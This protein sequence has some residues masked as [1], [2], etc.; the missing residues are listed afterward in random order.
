MPDPSGCPDPQQLQRLAEGR[1]PALDAAAL[2]QHVQGCRA[3]AALVAAQQEGTTLTRVVPGSAGAHPDEGTQVLASQ[4]LGAQPAPTAVLPPAEPVP[5]TLDRTAGPS[6]APGEGRGGSLEEVTSCLAPPQAPDEIGRLGSYR[7]LRVLGSGGMG[8][9]FESEDPQL[10]RRVALKVMRP[11]LAASATGRQRFIREAQLTASLEHDHI[12]EIHEVGEDRGVL[13]L[14]MQ[15][16]EGESLEDRLRRE[17]RLPLPEVLR[18]GRETTEGLVAAHERGLIHRDIKPANIWLEARGGPRGMPAPRPRVK[19]LDFGLARALDSDLHLT[20]S[21]I[22]AGT[23]QYMAPEQA[24]GGAVDARADLFSLGCVLYRMATGQAPFHGATTMAVL[25][26]LAVE[27][28]PDPRTLNPEVPPELAEL[29]GRQLAKRPVDRPATAQQVALTLQGLEAGLLAGETAEWSL[30]PGTAAAIAAWTRP[31]QPPVGATPGVSTVDLRS[32]RRQVGL[33]WALAAVLAALVLMTAGF[34]AVRVWWGADT[35]SRAPTAAD[36]LRREDMPPRVLAAAGDGD[37]HKAPAELVAVF[38]ETR[39]RSPA[40]RFK[41]P[42]VGQ[43]VPAHGIA[44]SSAGLLATASN[45]PFPQDEGGS[46]QLWD[47]HTGKVVRT[48]G[49]F[50]GGLLPLALSPDG[51]RLAAGLGTEGKVWDVNTGEPLFAL[52]WHTD[53][54]TC[55]AY[56]RDGKRLATGSYDRTVR[57]WDA[58]TAREEI[59]LKGH[60]GSVSAVVFHPDGK[61]LATAGADGH[62]RL[63]DLAGEREVRGFLLAAPALAVAVSPDGK[64]LAGGS[65]GRLKVW[66]LE[67]GREVLTL[68][69]QGALISGLA[70]SPDGKWLAGAG[71]QGKDVKVWNV[72]TWQE[73][74]TLTGNRGAVTALAFRA[75]G[76]RLAGGGNDQTVSLW[77]LTTDPERPPSQWHTGPVLA[78]AVSPDGNT[79]ASAGQDQTIRLWDIAGARWRATLTGHVGP[80]HHIAFSPDGQVL[81]SA[82]DDLTIKLWDVA[83]ARE[84]RTLRGHTERVTWVAFSADGGRLVS[85]GADRTV[86][87]WDSAT[88]A[89]LH[90]FRGHSA[91]VT[92]AAFSPDREKVVSGGLDKRLKVWELASG[93]AV[94]TL[95]GHTAAVS[96]LA[97][98]RGGS[99]LAS[100]GADQTVRLWDLDSGRER[101]TLIGHGAPVTAVAFRE[102]GHAVAS[103]S[104]D[105]TVRLWDL[106][107]DP[108]GKRIVRLFPPGTAV[109][110][111]AFS[112]EGRHLFTA[113]PNGT[114]YCLRL[115]A[116]VPAGE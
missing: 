53:R 106:T 2:E 61:R 105:G 74:F 69:E 49:K 64:W 15:L 7:V 62:V 63:W 59:C 55:I 81:A 90:T 100:G 51:K 23:P 43:M 18:L 89:E 103:A 54:I 75:D 40:A 17:R 24:E 10:K 50:R 70:F 66:D 99:M 44:F 78:V 36:R 14:A 79:L 68:A 60:L 45:T 32:P 39:Q 83:T 28:P 86:R 42:E 26:A 8:V 104:H 87:V 25:R 33:R 111:L 12:V 93:T 13:F 72:P 38:G 95:P 1:L 21:G 115:T 19:I 29:I 34:F 4:P 46:I 85:A 108:P 82:A 102:D 80:V 112:P 94:L 98:P 31:P 27:E 88:G 71:G 41:L 101:H 48:F 57:V 56:S 58:E 91:A 67:A 5:S 37:P 77:D 65:E 30:R 92:C 96:S 110:D 9:V 97:F 113:N 6:S 52:P 109:H 3:C 35:S 16:L 84:R 11:A 76:K 116:V 107:A 114:I 47:T 22:M 20:Q 73:A